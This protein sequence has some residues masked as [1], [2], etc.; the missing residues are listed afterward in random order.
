MANDL[1]GIKLNDPNNILLGDG[2][3]FFDYGETGEV[4][5]GATDGDSKFTRK[6]F[7]DDLHINGAGKM[8][9]KGL[10]VYQGATVTLSFGA[11]EIFPDNLAKFFGGLSS[12]AVTNPG[13]NTITGGA[14]KSTDYHTNV[15][16]VGQTK[17]GKECIIILKNALGTKDLELA[18]KEGDKVVTNVEFTATYDPASNNINNYTEPW[19]IRIATA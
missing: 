6:V 10:T 14:I 2:A 16:F 15:A 4:C 8:K 19:E 1:I 11:V 3:I 7:E 12:D 9:V 18:F 5:I 17:G 13:F